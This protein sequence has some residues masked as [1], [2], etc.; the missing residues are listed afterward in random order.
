MPK[1]KQVEFVLMTR[2]EHTKRY[3]SAEAIREAYED[4][5]ARLLTPAGVP[6]QF[7]TRAIIGKLT[8]VELV[9]TPI[10]VQINAT[11]EITD[12]DVLEGE[13]VMGLKLDQICRAALIGLHSVAI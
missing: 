9:D 10:L 8:K 4:L 6:I 12:A 1:P 5:S 3:I 11:A 2:D 13:G 7:Y